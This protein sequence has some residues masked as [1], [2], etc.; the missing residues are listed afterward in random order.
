[1]SSVDGA[2]AEVVTRSVEGRR[3]MFGGRDALGRCFTRGR[4]LD[5]WGEVSLSRWYVTGMS[6]CLTT[7]QVEAMLCDEAEVYELEEVSP[8]TT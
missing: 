6:F 4:G 5:G 7:I 3:G 8:W 2:C 1:M